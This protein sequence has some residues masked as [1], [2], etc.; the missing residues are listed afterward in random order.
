[1]DLRPGDVVLD[2]TFGFGGHS[3]KILEMIAPDGRIIAIDQ[4]PEVLE[5]TKR[6]FSGERVE[7]VNDNFVNIDAILERLKIKSVDAVL[8]DLGVSSFH[9]D[10]SGRGFSFSKDEPLDMRM[11]PGQIT[12][13]KDLVN[14]LSEKELADLI[15]QY[16]DE[17]DSRRIAKAIVEARRKEK[18]L[19]TGQLADI[20]IS[21]RRGFAKTHP[22]T[23]VFQALRIVVNDE[24]GVISETLPKVIRA[25][26]PGGRIAVI[27]F[28]SGE[29]RI[30]KNIFK[31]LRLKGKINLLTKKPVVPSRNEIG[32]NPRARSAKMR[33]AERI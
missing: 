15:F 6:E 30:V 10:E 12:R 25:L 17:R 11:D 31:E 24:L 14:G 28:H 7:F 9:F 32:A 20:I 33:V 8:M 5:K 29:D 21:V 13:A 23:K 1:M 19:T 3:R 2:A 27:S 4:D 16:G 22:A 18:I 26:A